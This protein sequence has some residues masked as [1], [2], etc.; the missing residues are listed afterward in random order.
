MIEEIP[1]D[2]AEPDVVAEPV[3]QKKR[4]R[5]AGSLNKA[6]SL[7]AVH[8]GGYPTPAQQPEPAAAAPQRGDTAGSAPQR[9]D[10]A[11]SA[12][13]RHDPPDPPAAPERQAS[14]ERPKPLAKTKRRRAR[15]P[16]LGSDSEPPTP[17]RSR[18]SCPQIPEVQDTATIATEV[19]KLLSNRHVDKS[20]ARRAKYSRWFL[21]N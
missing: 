1:L 9:G 14:K 13:S 20:E 8:T 5:P 15:P 3:A 21:P 7:K 19:L 10:T 6:K 12:P 16:S 4:G 18:R 11:G 17:D 2:L